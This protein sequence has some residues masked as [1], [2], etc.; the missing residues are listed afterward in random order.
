[1]RELYNK[2]CGSK[3]RIFYAL[4][5]IYP[6][7]NDAFTEGRKMPLQRG[8]NKKRVT[9]VTQYLVNLKS[10]TMKNTMQRY[11]LF[12]KMQGFCQKKCIYVRKINLSKAFCCKM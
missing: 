1:M 7:E 9:A 8:R 10:N 12:E 4:I 5:L 6:R 11:V 2:K 3:G